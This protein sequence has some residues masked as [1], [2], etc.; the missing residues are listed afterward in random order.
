MTASTAYGMSFQQLVSIPSNVA[1]L[2]LVIPLFRIRLGDV[3]EKLLA[4]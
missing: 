1:F 4:R 2:P 3:S